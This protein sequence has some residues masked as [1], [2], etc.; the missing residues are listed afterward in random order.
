MAR[1]GR[2]PRAQTR[3]PAPKLEAPVEIRASGMRL[4]AEEY[5]VLSYP[6]PKLVLPE[7]L[8]SAEREVA[9]ALLA[10]DAYA[11]IAARR[12]TALRTVANQVASIFRKAG[13]RSRL[14]LAVRLSG[15]S[16]KEG[17]K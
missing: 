3:T 6:V 13:V 5:V 10:G 15:A 8:T 1:S 11:Q 14:E 7:E 2:T 12:R 9:L 17:V 4:G 16:L